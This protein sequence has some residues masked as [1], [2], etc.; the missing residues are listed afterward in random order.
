MAFVKIRVARGAGQPDYAVTLIEEGGQETQAVL[1]EADVM[2][3]P[4]QP[5]SI[6]KRVSGAGPTNRN[7]TD[8]QA[9]AQTLYDWLLPAG[10]VRQRWMALDNSIQPR[11]LL[12]IQADALARLPWELT[13]TEWLALTNGLYRLGGA[14]PV[15]EVQPVPAQGSL[16][17]FRI[18]I[19]VGCLAEE[20]AA[21]RI[22]E[23]VTEIE[24]TFL[25]LGR[26]VDVH[27]LDRPDK[28]TLKDWVR[29]FHP[30]VLHFAG[31]GNKLPAS[32]KIGLRFNPAGANPWIWTGSDIRTDLR[33]WRWIPRFVFLNACRSAA[34]QEGS[35]SVQRGF[36]DRGTQ[37]AL[38]MQADMRGDLAGQFAAKLYEQCALGKTL[39]DAVFEARQT[40]TG[41]LPS[42]DHIDWALPALTATAQ[43]IRLF[44]PPLSPTSL[45]YE[46][47]REFREARFFANCREPRRKF[48]H[49]VYPAD[50]APSTKNVLVVTGEPKS[51]KSHLLKWCMETWAL[52]GARVRYIELHWQSKSLL[53]VLRQIRKGEPDGTTESQYLHAPLPPAAF[54]RFK[55]ELKNL[56]ETNETGE[57][58]EADHINDPEIPDDDGILPGK[59]EKLLEPVV[60]ARFWAALK[61]AA[62][63]RPLILVFDRLGGPNNERTL[64]MRDF[65]QLILN[66]F[67]PIAQETNSIIKLAFSASGP[68]ATDYKLGSL[69]AQNTVKFQVP[70]EFDDEQLAKLAAEMLWFHE[71]SEIENLAKRLFLFP[72]PHRMEKGLAR[73][74]FVLEAL[75]DTSILDQVT[76]M[77]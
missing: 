51:G 39:E 3:G 52:G 74:K 65:E 6:L 13:S 1:T 18:L 2:K 30:H 9:I 72:R 64:M 57:W 42:N 17:P 45:E 32:P 26:S 58:T 71:E 15:P 20:E 16:W 60:C 55:W 29:T 38:G 70:T 41:K 54:K 12:D 24:R 68:E 27:R 47:C 5:D 25:P 31:H 40:M 22:A 34:E 14:Q 28:D 33:A 44:E 37:A 69:P 76:R 73:L 56:I 67:R 77:Q 59:G 46:Q 66:L 61:A 75:K 50:Q 35:Y 49:W 63:A 19:V 10:P 7:S 62:G 23:E 48:T 36:L 43:G 4:W 53:D 11:L 21:L 8:F